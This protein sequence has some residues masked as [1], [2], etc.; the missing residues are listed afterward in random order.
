LV[1]GFP[2]VG[3][4]VVGTKVAFSVTVICIEVFV[5]V[6]VVTRDALDVADSE[7][8]ALPEKE[9]APQQPA[10]AGVM[11]AGA[12]AAAT[13]RHFISFLNMIYS[14]PFDPTHS[15]VFGAR[16]VT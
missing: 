3:A 10:T 6:S 1:S 15:F 5:T 9:N 13:T 7:F 14:P 12:T 16:P 2:R 11:P 8:V 4:A